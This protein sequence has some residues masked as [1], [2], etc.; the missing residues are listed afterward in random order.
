MPTSSPALLL[1]HESRALDVLRLSYAAAVNIATAPGAY[2]NLCHE[3][4][5]RDRDGTSQLVTHL[6]SGDEPALLG[7]AADLEQAEVASPLAVA[8]AQLR[9]QALTAGRVLAGSIQPGILGAVLRFAADQDWYASDEVRNYR[10]YLPSLH[11]EPPFASEED[12]AWL[13]TFAASV[14]ASDSAIT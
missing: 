1:W 2:F 6:Y 10:P 9:L 14:L 4:F 12:E 8:V 11:A 13:L 3:A 5:G 7:L